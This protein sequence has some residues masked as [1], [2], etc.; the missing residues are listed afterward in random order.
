MNLEIRNK[1]QVLLLGRA[2][3]SY[4]IGYEV[5]GDEQIPISLPAGTALVPER[6]VR[7]DELSRSVVASAEAIH[8]YSSDEKFEKV[9]FEPQLYL[10]K[11]SKFKAVLTP[12][13][14]VTSGMPYSTRVLQT[15]LSRQVGAIWASHG[16]NVITSV[17]WSDNKDFEI[18]ITGIPRNSIIAVGTYGLMRNSESKRVLREGLERLVELLE[19]ASILIFGAIDPD[20]HERLSKTTVIRKFTPEHWAKPDQ[21]RKYEQTLDLFD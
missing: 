15:R 4:P 3:K 2:P 8:F 9:L 7:F 10:E 13:C 21:I 16:L 5:V 6:L 11:F 18:A 14:S 1:S 12:D 17:R 20:L 19:P